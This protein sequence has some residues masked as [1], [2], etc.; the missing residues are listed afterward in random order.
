MCWIISTKQ[1]LGWYVEVMQ[2]IA[3][4]ANTNHYQQLKTIDNRLS[5]GYLY[6]TKWCRVN[7]NNTVL[8]QSVY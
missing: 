6:E 3:P 7:T 5:I 4:T 8:V 1:V 2:D